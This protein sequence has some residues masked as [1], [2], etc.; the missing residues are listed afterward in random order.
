MS[1][2]VGALLLAAG[3]S[4]RFGGSKLL[5]P[6]QSGQTVFQQTLDRL[7]AAVTDIV[8]ITRPELAEEL[9]PYAP[10]LKVFAE[11]DKGMGASLA[12]GIEFAAQWD[13]CLICLADMPFIQS[14]TYE[15]I[16]NAAQSD[17][18]VIPQ[19]DEKPGNPVAFGSDFY[20][21]L[22]DLSGD[23][24][25]RPVVKQH[26][27][28]LCRLEIDDAAILADIDTPQDLNALQ[29]SFA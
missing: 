5:A 10:G 15:D 27:S 7:S 22:Q 17:N 21:E 12:Y 16:A 11:S 24:G 29:R 20:R 26:L 2:K 1:K 14:S 8:V 4:K 3:F 28:Q 18:I 25:G 23:A 9:S 19:F 6:L 13:A